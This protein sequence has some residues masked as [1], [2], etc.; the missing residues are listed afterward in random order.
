MHEIEKEKKNITEIAGATSCFHL[1]DW[2]NKVKRLEL[3]KLRSL[4]NGS[5]VAG[6]SEK[7][8]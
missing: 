6:I 4:E 2:G 7:G 5:H 3:L 8:H 1:Y